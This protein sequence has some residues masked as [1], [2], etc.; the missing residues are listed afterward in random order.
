MQLRGCRSWNLIISA[1]I[2][3]RPQALDLM[4]LKRIQNWWESSFL[5]L[6]A[7][8]EE[9]PSGNESFVHTKIVFALCN[10]VANNFNANITVKID[11]W[12]QVHMLWISNEKCRMTGIIL[13][14]RF[15]VFV[16]YD[17]SMSYL[18]NYCIVYALQSN[19]SRY[20]QYLILFP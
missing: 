10:V 17:I 12:W 14:F 16:V 15:Y 2:C 7:L 5:E 8:N 3:L 9:T 18:L 13:F 19:S 11:I 1:K 4:L 20:Y 6:Q